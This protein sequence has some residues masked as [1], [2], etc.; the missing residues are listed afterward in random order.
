MEQ[1]FLPFLIYYWFFS[2][3]LPFWQWVIGTGIILIITLKMRFDTLSSRFSA[4]PAL[5]RWLT[6][7]TALL[8][9]FGT[10]PTS[11]LYGAMA[12]ELGANFGRLVDN[13]LRLP[14][15][16]FR[17]LAGSTAGI[18]SVTALIVWALVIWGIIGAVIGF[19]LNIAYENLRRRS[20]GPST[21]P[22]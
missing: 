20:G 3:L 17:V 21:G 13:F 9:I 8:G 11:F 10:M 22:T 5:I 6:M 1:A 14:W 18:I 12:G 19:G 2:L 4:L 15:P 16:V 7:A